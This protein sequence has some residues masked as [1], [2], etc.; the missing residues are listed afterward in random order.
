[1]WI[2]P[3]DVM[4][5]LA[6]TADFFRRRGSEPS[7]RSGKWNLENKLFHHLTA[8]AGLAVVASGLLMM[9]RIDT[10]FW[11]ANPYFRDI[12]DTTWGIVF[13]VHGAAAVGFVGL[14]MA[15]IYFALRPEKLWFTRSMFKGWITREEYL[16]HFDP[17][18]WQVARGGSA[19]RPGAALADAADAGT[20]VPVEAA[21]ILAGGPGAGSAIPSGIVGEET[22]PGGPGEPEAASTL[23]ADRK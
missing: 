14:L 1:M 11:K 19:T 22:E 18:R 8:L 21:P 10:W 2:G 7:T 9:A 20:P 17:E 4:S 12:P 13:V 5:G 23:A 3:R 6:R 15:H 16:T